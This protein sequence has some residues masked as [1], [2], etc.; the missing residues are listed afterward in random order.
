M[1]LM[2]IEWKWNIP[3]LLSLLRIL[4]V[5]VF[6]ILYNIGLGNDEHG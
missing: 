6:V 2:N 4:L 1:Q 3:N 5:P